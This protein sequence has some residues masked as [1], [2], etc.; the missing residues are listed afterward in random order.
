MDGII[1]LKPIEKL[2]KKQT[3]NLVDILNNDPKLSRSIGNKNKNISQKEFVVRNKKWSNKNNAKLFAILLS[4]IAIGMISLS[5][6]N[7][8]NKTARIGYWA[9]SLYWNKG[10][11]GEAFEQILKIAKKNNIKSVSCTIQ[12]ENQAS[13]KIWQKY[14]AEFEEKND[15]L[16]PSIKI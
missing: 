11:V 13:K 1:K 14:N 7:T 2:N 3:S 16:I 15:K 4:D 10:F 6:I 12:K 9:G 5:H 8:G